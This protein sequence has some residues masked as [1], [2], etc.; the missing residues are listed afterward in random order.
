MIFLRQTPSD[1][2]RL[3]TFPGFPPKPLVDSLPHATHSPSPPALLASTSHLKPQWNPGLSLSSRSLRN[4]RRLVSLLRLG[5]PRGA[6]P[7][8]APSS[9]HRLL[10]TT[11]RAASAKHRLAHPVK[12]KVFI[13]FA[14][15]YLLGPAANACAS[16]LE[17]EYPLPSPLLF[18]LTLAAIGSWMPP[19]MPI[20]SP[21]FH[22]RNPH[23]PRSTHPHKKKR[24]HPIFCSSANPMFS[25]P[26]R[27]APTPTTTPSRFFAPPPP[28]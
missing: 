12:L 26:I 11:P 23:Q 17:T 8:E 20:C 1:Q 10:A 28:L 4:S 24:T 25:L 15:P 18:V 2:L 6:C 3:K 14:R 5:S 13:S 21:S 19:D 27:S 16:N 9:R 22:L 7:R